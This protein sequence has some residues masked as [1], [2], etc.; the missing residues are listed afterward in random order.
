M[1]EYGKPEGLGGASGFWDA[2]SIF[3]ANKGAVAGLVIWFLIISVA[4]LGPILYP[5]NPFQIVSTPMSPPSAK[6]ILGSDYMGRDVLA[7][8]IHG[9]KVTLL[10]G[11]AATFCTVIIGVL[12]GTLAGYYGGRIDLFLMRITEFFQVLPPILLAMVLVTLF[13]P[14]Y[15]TVVVSIGAVNWISTARLTR[16]AFLTIKEMDFVCAARAT[17][18]TNSRIMWRTILP[19]AFPPLIVIT[20]L[21]IGSAILFEAALSFLGLTD[22][23][24]MT[25]GFMIGASRNYIWDSWWAVTFPGVAIFL[26]VLSISLIGDG[27]NDALNLKLRVL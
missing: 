19:N 10:V 26:T 13:S 25:W 9:A 11:F 6:L 24:V 5:G 16:A 14:S 18:A 1:A 8:I 22:P 12:V 20:T 15:I 4:I 17:G 7:G 23:N 3:S 21:T 27:L 2:W